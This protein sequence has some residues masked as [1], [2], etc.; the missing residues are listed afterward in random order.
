M[1]AAWLVHRTHIDL[2]P[3][4][5]IIAAAVVSFATL[6]ALE[7]KAPVALATS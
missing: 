5:M 2:T 4:F 1:A 6:L 7:R 3:A